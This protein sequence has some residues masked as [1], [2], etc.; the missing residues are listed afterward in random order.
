[1]MRTLAAIVI[2]LSLNSA[3]ADGLRVYTEN[4]RP[5]QF[6]SQTGELKGFGIEL[7]EAMFNE[8][9][10]EIMD[11]IRMSVWDT[12]YQR[13][14]EEPDAAIF[15]TVRNAARENLFQWV[16]PLAPR[17]MWLYKLSERKDIQAKSLEEAKK[18]TVGTYKSA[19][20][21]HLQELGFPKLDIILKEELNIKKL[22]AGR[23]DLIPATEAMMVSK[24]QELEQDQ[25]S[26]EKVVLL[27]DRFSYY[28]AI[29]KQADATLVQ[30]L[31]KALDELK[32][33]GFY[34]ARHQEYMQGKF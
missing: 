9:N 15:M 5:Y 10:I 27:D 20:S 25:S 12:A 11:G 14:L 1:M 4:F 19:Q 29:N 2:T 32:Q 8:A 33:N 17:S 6:Q 24:L 31:Q 18:Y 21:D 28:L 7:I 23:V 16:G 3:F 26:V 34:Q 22:F 13:T 30:K